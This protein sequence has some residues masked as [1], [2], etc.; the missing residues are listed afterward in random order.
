MKVPFLIKAVYKCQANSIFF[1]HGQ[2][3]TYKKEYVVW[4]EPEDKTNWRSKIA[5][6]NWLSKNLIFKTE[7]RNSWQNVAD[8]RVLVKKYFHRLAPI[9]KRL[10]FESPQIKPP[11]LPIA[12]LLYAESCFGS[13]LHKISLGVFLRR[14]FIKISVSFSDMLKMFEPFEILKISDELVWTCST[15]LEKFK[16]KTPCERKKLSS[17]CKK[18]PVQKNP[19]IHTSW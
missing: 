15:C 9:R 5:F 18:N 6:Q 10:L 19:I 14:Y 4:K 11:G 12:S 7:L 1:R 13:M 8:W 3:K 2:K 17:L 16:V